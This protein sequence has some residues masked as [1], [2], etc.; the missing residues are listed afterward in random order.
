MLSKLPQD[1][2]STTL[3][4]QLKAILGPDFLPSKQDWE[5]TVST[6]MMTAK[7]ANKSFEFERAVIILEAL[8]SI[9]SSQGKQEFSINCRIQLLQEKGHAFGSLGKYDEA[10]SEFKKILTICQDNN[11][12]DLKSETYTQIGQLL[13]KQGDFERALGFLQR[14][15]G[16]YRRSNDNTGL[17]KALRN[18]GVV[19]CELGDFDEA[20]SAISEAITISAA[21]ADNLLY[22][23]LVNNLG[24]I[25]N[26]K[27]KRSRALELYRESLE[28]YV[29]NE[30][31][32]KAAYTKNNIGI[33][34]SELGHVTDAYGYFRG[35]YET[36]LKINDAYLRLIAAI[37]LADVYLKRGNFERAKKHSKWAEKYL[38]D[39]KLINVNLIEAKK[40]NG[41]I[42][43]AE[44]H[45]DD[46]LNEFNS[47]LEVCREIGSKFHEAEVLMERGKLL[48]VTEQHFDALNDLETSYYIFKKI[49]AEGKQLHTEKIIDSVEHLY[50]EIF[51]SMGKMVDRKDSYTKGHSDRVASL[52]LL[53]A[54]ELGLKTSVVKTIV[55]AALLHDIG[56]VEIS[57]SILK[58]PGRLTDEEFDEIKKHP[59][60]G[61]EMLRGKE[62][63]WD[64]KP[65][66]L[67]HHE[68]VNGS[69]YPM[70]IKGDDIPLGARLICIADVFE[71]LTSDRCYR[72]A[73]SVE[74]ALGIM[75][76]ES[77]TTFD[78][79][80]LKSFVALVERGDVDYIINARTRHD[81]MYKIWSLCMAADE[82]EQIQELDY[83]IS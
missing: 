28:I 77:G 60:Y 25:M 32:R 44:K 35:S 75:K 18:L 45:Y 61:L 73:F 19:Y 39:E 24:A 54:K 20:E 11:E 21:A 62:F 67:H 57:D 6:L 76:S 26:M 65:L 48:R 30:E 83:V 9:C 38:T 41:R 3:D 72:D 51:N 13:A 74:K 2:K 40:L 69:G 42:C 79:V 47:A 81:A 80:L 49:K 68:R 22:A 27:G 36:S 46:A 23:D 10:I 55:A 63:P 31:I 59:E 70:K 16:A 29:E 71:A 64:I 7:E 1:D 15:I 4:D 50:L 53:L 12:L 66:I 14:A 58:K 78:P 43:F 8:E 52:S 33:S 17:C 82:P 34:L 56:K 37:N 5:R